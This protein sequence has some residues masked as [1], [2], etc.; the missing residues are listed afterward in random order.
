MRHFIIARW[1]IADTLKQKII[2]FAH[3]LE[4]STSQFRKTVKSESYNLQGKG[5]NTFVYIRKSNFQVSYIQDELIKRTGSLRK[6][7]LRRRDTWVT[8]Q[9]LSIWTPPAI[10]CCRAVK[11]RERVILWRKYSTSPPGG[12]QELLCWLKSSCLQ[13]NSYNVGHFL[14]GSMTQN[15]IMVTSLQSTNRGLSINELNSAFA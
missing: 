12:F 4:Y 3:K 10:P 14:F 8:H 13:N 5:E 9:T 2:R 1:F 15:L 7:S 11:I 6:S